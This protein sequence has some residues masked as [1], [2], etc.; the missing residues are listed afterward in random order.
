MNILLVE[1]DA[2]SRKA[3]EGCL[4]CR[5][6]KVSSVFLGAD[7]ISFATLSDFDVIFLD[8]GLPD[9][10]GHEVFA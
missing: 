3:L 1:D 5:N 6:F 4:S 10:L 8:L 7:A 2:H 9:M